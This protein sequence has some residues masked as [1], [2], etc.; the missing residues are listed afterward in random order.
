MQLWIR[1]AEPPGSCDLRYGSWNN[2]NRV[3]QSSPLP[4]TSS[5]NL[6]KTWTDK[7]TSTCLWNPTRI[8]PTNKQCIEHDILAGK[9]ITL[10]ENMERWSWCTEL[11]IILLKYQHPLF[12][13]PSRVVQSVGHLTRK[14]GV[15]GPI[16]GLATNFRFSFRF[17]KK[18][19]CQLLAKVCARSTG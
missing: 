1:T 3:Y 19:S 7:M 14:S 5:T 6:Q 10:T 16:R 13:R 2:N 4:F 8:L 12:F 17:F 15:L 18:D 11:L 9:I